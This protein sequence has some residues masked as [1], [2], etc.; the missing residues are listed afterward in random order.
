MEYN[1]DFERYMFPLP[2]ESMFGIN[3]VI[4]VVMTKLQHSLTS[5]NTPVVLRKDL[6][7]IPEGEAREGLGMVLPFVFQWSFRIESEDKS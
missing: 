3:M 5:E 6:E 4:M 7:Q 1:T 2:F